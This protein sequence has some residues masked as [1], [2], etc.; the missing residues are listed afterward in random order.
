M[1][2]FH[3]I[4]RMKIHA[5]HVDLFVNWFLMT[6]W[7]HSLALFLQFVNSQNVTVNFCSALNLIHISD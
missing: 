3:L 7:M 2:S 4:Q 6:T 5:L 1:L